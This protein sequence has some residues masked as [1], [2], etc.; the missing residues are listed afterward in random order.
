MNASKARPVALSLPHRFAS[1]ITRVSGAD[2]D[3]QFL[4]TAAQELNNPITTIKTALT[5]LNTS[6]L[7]PKTASNAISR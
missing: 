1:S 7:K 3:T 6:T 5:L 2:V 4:K